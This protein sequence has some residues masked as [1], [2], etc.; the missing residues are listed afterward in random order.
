M[1]NIGAR[2]FRRLGRLRVPWLDFKVGFRMLARYPGL[3]LVGTV[4]MAIAVALGTVYF[5]GLRKWEDPRLPVRDPVRVISILEWDRGKAMPDGQS[6]YDFTIW[7]DQVKTVDDVGAAIVFTRNLVTADRAVEAV[8]GA[9]VT[10]S[11]FRLMETP[12]LLGRTFTERDEQLG[13]PAVVVIGYALWTSRFGSNPGVLGRAVT[14]GTATATIVGV[15]PDGFGFPATQRIWLPLRIDRSAVTPGTGPSVSVFGRLAAGASI[16]SAEAELRTI[17]TRIAATDPERHNNLTPRVT[18]YETPI[19]ESREGLFVKSL[20]H[21]VN[22]IFVLLLA[23]VCVNVATLVFARAATRG[24]EITVRT[25]LG[26]TRSRIVAQLYVEALVLASAATVLGLALAKLS[27]RWGL[28]VVGRASLPF[29]ITDSLSWVTV[30]YAVFLTIF[31]AA[32]V[33]ILPALRVTNI[34]V[35]D[36]LRSESGARATLRFGGFWTTVIVVQVAITVALLPIAGNSAFQANRFR[37]RAEGI[38]ADQYLTASI[39]FENE[40]HTTDAAA[41]AA[42]AR[43][44]F[45]ELERRLRADPDVEQVTFADRLPVMDQ[46]KF[47]IQLDAPDAAQNTGLRR[48]RRV[49]VSDGFFAT[50]GTSIVAGRDFGPLDFREDRVLIVNQ[51][52]AHYVFG[53]RNP[54]GRR[55]RIVRNEDGDDDTTVAREHWYEIV[56]IVRDFGWQLPQPEEQAAMYLPHLP[57]A[58]E[59]VNLALRVHDPDAFAARLRKVAFDVDP[60][61]PLTDI[62]PLAEVGGADAQ[63]V[64]TLNAVAWV[65]SFIVLLLSATGIHALMSFVVTRQTREIGIRVA[66]GARPGR[67]LTGIFSR[68][69]LQIGAGVVAGSAVAALWGLDSTRQV[70]LLLAANGVMLLVG[71]A[72]CAL[73]LKRALSIDPAEALRAEG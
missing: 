46:S 26:A 61:L 28:D 9:E 65:I 36:A 1:A 45:D 67:I 60:R 57:V 29:W 15:M 63:R 59:R 8:P 68:A 41:F 39:D 3:T 10:A 7:R 16:R 13:A 40:D 58:G 33:G 12:P 19:L 6:L 56:G 38:G 44:R 42:R 47:Q 27:L 55:I 73:P 25:A 17:Q 72:A 69:F 24:W 2:A 30:L 52:F 53:D 49:R 62:Q 70:L 34:H 50:F 71:V 35:Q 54:V 21:A 66:L 11:A 23:I 14:L 64:W 4:A 51:A 18:T 22:G 37:Q 31:G 32:I 20:L 43:L 48:S 5:E